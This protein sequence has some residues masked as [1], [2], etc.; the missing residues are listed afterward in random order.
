ME[1]ESE[2]RKFSRSQSAFTLIE[3]LVVIGIIAILAAMLLPALSSAKR[4]AA[5][6][7]DFNNERQIGLGMKMYVNDDADQYPG[8]ASRMYGFH[9]EDWIY[10][11]TNTTSY[12]PFEK[13]PIVTAMAGAQRASFRCPLD[14]DDRDRLD[15]NDPIYA[16]G[17]GA[18]NF[19]FSFTGYGAFSNSL[20]AGMSTV[21]DATGAVT[22]FK[23]LAVRN[24]A[25]KI[26]I[27]EEPG[28]RKPKDSPDGVGFIVDGR[29]IPTSDP[30]T[31]RHSGRA[32]VGFADGHVG[33]AKPEDGIDIANSLPSL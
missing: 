3:L 5:Q 1:S 32:D 15:L 11:R 25:G 10:W 28:S 9:A 2:S 31:I 19:S 29:W 20:N 24:P 16:D 6:S 13:S 21:V 23:E 8:I 12:P 22:P 7:T 17:F 18:Y 26:M 14:N 30:L 33:T 4:R 27:A